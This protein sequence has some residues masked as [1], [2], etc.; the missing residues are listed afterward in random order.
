MNLALFT[1]LWA[2]IGLLL[3]GIINVLSDDLPDRRRPRR[4]HCPQCEH[5]YRPGSWLAI[6]RRLRSSKCPEC[7]LPHRQRPLSV[8]LGMVLLFGALPWLIEP[9]IDLAIYSAYIAVLILVIVI[10]LEHRL[11]LHVVTIPTTIFALLASWPLTDSAFLLALV[12]AVV[13]FVFFRFMRLN[14]KSR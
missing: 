7:G 13:G 10:D 11:V 4:P 5:A 14:L 3:G 9:P 8:E 12:G 1:I 2:I 6:A